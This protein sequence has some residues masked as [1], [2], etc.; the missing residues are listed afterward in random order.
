MTSDFSYY[1]WQANSQQ[2][3][4]SH[5]KIF[6]LGW[7]GFSFLDFHQSCVLHHQVLFYLLQLTLDGVFLFCP[8]L[9]RI[10][11]KSALAKVCSWLETFYLQQSFFLTFTFFLLLQKWYLNLRCTFFFIIFPFFKKIPETQVY[12]WVELVML[13]CWTGRL[14]IATLYWLQQST[15][16]P[17]QSG[18]L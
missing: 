1:I 16:W 8:C 9:W 13:E 7:L 15:S 17:I 11:S 18:S 6:L 3:Q 10:S 5:F 4:S 14:A 12:R 2:T